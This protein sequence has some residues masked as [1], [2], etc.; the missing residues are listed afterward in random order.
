MLLIFHLESG[1]SALNAANAVKKILFT[2]IILN[3][4]GKLGTKRLV[5]CT[6][7]VHYAMN[8]QIS[9]IVAVSSLM[10]ENYAMNS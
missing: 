8:G 4:A 10:L 7:D 9:G 3:W 1:R 6:C 2:G 5:R